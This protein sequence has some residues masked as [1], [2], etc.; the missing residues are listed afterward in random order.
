MEQH[1]HDSEILAVVCC[2]N[3]CRSCPESESESAKSLE[4]ESESEQHY[5]DSQTQ[6]VL[7]EY[8]WD[9]NIVLLHDTPVIQSVMWRNIAWQ[10]SN[11]ICKPPYIETNPWRADGL[12]RRI[13]PSALRT[14]RE[15][16]LDWFTF[17][18]FFKESLKPH[19]FPLFGSLQVPR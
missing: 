4:S 10:H 7:I 15:C 6:Q 11:S 19:I 8:Y 2:C 3:Q 5:H 1:H 17:Y 18:F 16:I 13:V 12:R 9:H 14:L